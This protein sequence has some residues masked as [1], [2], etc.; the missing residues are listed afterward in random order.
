MIEIE[1]E[2]EVA[3]HLRQKI[4][5]M[6]AGLKDAP[7]LFRG[8]DTSPN[9]LTEW[10]LKDLIDTLERTLKYFEG[11][12]VFAHAPCWADQHEDHSHES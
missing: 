7:N 1:K 8:D 6:V 10:M 11:I 12:K 4:I 3:V 2:Y 5:D 9:G